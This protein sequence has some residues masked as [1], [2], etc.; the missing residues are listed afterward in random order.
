MDN[1]AEG[2]Y[3][4]G[5]R[6]LR[7]GFNERNLECGFSNMLLKTK[8]DEL[9]IQTMPFRELVAFASTFDVVCATCIGAGMSLLNARDACISFPRI[10][11][12]EAAQVIEPAVLVPLA[13]GSDQVVLVGDHCQLPALVLSRDAERRGLGVSMMARLASAGCEV[14]MLQTQYRMHSDIAS[15]N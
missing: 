10:I 6:V 11:V 1:L 4:R 7:V 2:L 8:S 14:A 12:D 15:P 5:V 9:A 13:K 3:S